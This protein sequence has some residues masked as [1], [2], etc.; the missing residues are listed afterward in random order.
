M[1]KIN[2]K[3]DKTENPRRMERGGSRRKGEREKGEK[4][5]SSDLVILM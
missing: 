5:P 2:K 4:G 1:R 3:R